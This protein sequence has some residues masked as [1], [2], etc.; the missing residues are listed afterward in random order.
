MSSIVF[1]T[2]RFYYKG[3]PFFRIRRL[4]SYPG[5]RESSSSR[6]ADRGKIVHTISF[7]TR[8]LSLFQALTY[9]QGFLISNKY[10][11]VI[12]KNKV[13]NIFGAL[14]LLAIASLTTTGCVE[15]QYYHE[16]HH[17][18]PDYYHRHHRTPPAGVD[19]D[20]HN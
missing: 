11:I 8:Q 7:P 13:R 2:A 10:K 1:A 15:H 14:L 12:M 4:P 3:C 18:S 20:I 16:H 19:I 9:W 17:H 6:P 5:H